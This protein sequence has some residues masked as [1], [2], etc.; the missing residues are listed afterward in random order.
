VIWT[1]PLAVSLP[2]AARYLGYRGV[3]PD[4]TMDERIEACILRVREA[5]RPVHVRALF[6]I[7][8]SDPAEG[9]F[10]I[11]TM[12][13]TSVDLARNLKDC[14]EAVFFAVTL[15]MGI[16]RMIRRAELT[17]MLEAAMIQAVAAELTEGYCNVVNEEI[18]QEAEA[19]GMYTRPRYSPGFGDFGLPYQPKFL[20]MLEASKKIGIK[21]TDGLLMIP[22]KSVT[23]VVGLSDR[24]RALPGKGNE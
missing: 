1:D 7:A 18:R 16:D 12:H 14:S 22:S 8:W 23:A 5:A 15:G 11:G 19:R 6:P 10:D 9:I 17:S 4:E 2:D 24:P 20:E 21:L 13:V 3:T